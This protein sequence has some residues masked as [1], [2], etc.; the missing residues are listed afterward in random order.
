MAVKTD[1]LP[2]VLLLYE[3]IVR[4]AQL[5]QEEGG[6]YQEE[7][8]AL[9]EYALF[10]HGH[11]INDRAMVVCALLDSFYDP[12]EPDPDQRDNRARLNNFMGQLH[13]EREEYEDAE[14]RFRVSL[15]LYR[16]LAAEGEDA[17]PEAAEHS[18]QVTSR[19]C[20]FSAWRSA[21][22]FSKASR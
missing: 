16:R 14:A 18:I 5:Y 8:E 3:E 2:D 4:M 6:A 1:T 13:W 12:D 19:V 22:S 11:G 7:L 17:E 15:D 10:L 20:C 21:Q 9:Y